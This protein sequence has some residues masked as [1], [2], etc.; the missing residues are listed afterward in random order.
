M[1]NRTLARQC[2]HVQQLAC[3]DRAAP[4]GTLQVVAYWPHTRK[5]ECQRLPREKASQNWATHRE[6]VGLSTTVKRSALHLQWVRRH[7]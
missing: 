3:P 2:N 5:R 6:D 1:K 4:T 7:R